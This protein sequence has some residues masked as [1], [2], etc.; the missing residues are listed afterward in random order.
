VY[1]LYILPGELVDT[2]ERW[3]RKLD[4]TG[5]SMIRRICEFT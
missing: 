4:R 3:R 5:R 1:I 2:C